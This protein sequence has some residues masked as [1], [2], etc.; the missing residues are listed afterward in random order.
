MDVTKQECLEIET[1]QVVRLIVVM[2]AIWTT[3]RDR[4]DTLFP[5]WIFK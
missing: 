1:R 3:K 5:Q 4:F 2:M